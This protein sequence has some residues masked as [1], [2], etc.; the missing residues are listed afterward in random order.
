[1]EKQ[2]EL[3]NKMYIAEF[4]Q[5]GDTKRADVRTD[6]GIESVKSMLHYAFGVNGSDVKIIRE[7]TTS[8]FVKAGIY[9]LTNVNADEKEF[10]GG[11]EFGD[12]KMFD[13]EV[14]NESG[15]WEAV[16]PRALSMYEANDLKRTYRN[17]KIVHHQLALSFKDGGGIKLQPELVKVGNTYHIKDRQGNE[18]DFTISKIENNI[19]YGTRDKTEASSHTLHYVA[20]YGKPIESS[21]S[22]QEMR[23]TYV[24]A[25]GKEYDSADRK[26]LPLPLHMAYTVA[27]RKLNPEKKCDGGIMEKG[28]ELKLETFS[29]T[30]PKE[31][32][33]ILKKF[34]E[35]RGIKI[36]N[37]KV[38]RYSDKV[39]YSFKPSDMKSL[40]EFKGISM[41]YGFKF[42]KGGSI[43]S[44][45]DEYID[46]LQHKSQIMVVYPQTYEPL[47][48]EFNN[49]IINELKNESIDNGKFDVFLDKF[50]ER[51]NKK[52]DESTTATIV[53]IV[54][55]SIVDEF[56]KG[57]NIGKKPAAKV[58]K[59]KQGIY[60]KGGK[61][62]CSK[63]SKLQTLLF[64]KKYFTKEQA[65][66]WLKKYKM[67]TG[68]DE[69]TNTYRAR[70]LNPDLFKKDSFRTMA[71]K[72]GVW[73][74]V[75]CPVK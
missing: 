56:K 29:I 49:K 74:V 67:K 58:H 62:Y 75:A 60:E 15:E 57:G 34:M 30:A 11:G 72:K 59:E 51:L 8:G 16:N 13:V 27:L 36:S 14:Q 37:T 26:Q 64:N 41:D 61:I 17:G 32:E 47:A 31:K 53:S 63:G 54:K 50:N 70:Q 40:D 22:E 6:G 24:K 2:N 28:G 71:F 39:T 44:E 43:G 65:I 12:E 5:Y 19:A 21:V 10:S 45:M 42:E 55:D 66:E 69:V 38:E 46:G 35:Q 18:F 3:T 25:Y 1:M 7:E 48:E 23:A 68:I 20:F 73:G 33:A 4:S 52:V 9:N